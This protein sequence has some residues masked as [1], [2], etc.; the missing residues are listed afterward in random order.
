MMHC[1]VWSE[2]VFKSTRNM[3]EWDVEY[4]KHWRMTRHP[5]AVRK[6]DDGFYPH[7][8]IGEV[9]GRCE[10]LLS[11]PGATG[12]LVGASGVGKTRILRRLWAQCSS[13]HQF[14]APIR[15]ASEVSKHAASEANV[16]EEKRHY[17]DLE[18]ATAIEFL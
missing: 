5:F 15:G 14:S 11:R 6:H 2:G 13:H 18:H 3:A 8:A 7:G 1:L 10:A 16:P 4:W 9:L 12:L 17:I